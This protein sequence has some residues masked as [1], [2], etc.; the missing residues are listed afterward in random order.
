[1]RHANVLEMLRW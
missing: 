1:M